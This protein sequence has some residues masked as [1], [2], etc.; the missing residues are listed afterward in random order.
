MLSIIAIA[1]WL[2]LVLI[3]NAIHPSPSQPIEAYIQQLKTQRDMLTALMV[4]LPIP[5]L[6]L[7]V[8]FIPYVN[9]LDVVLSW[10]YILT[11]VFTI[12]FMYRLE[13]RHHYAVIYTTDEN[14]NTQAFQFFKAAVNKIAEEE[15]LPIPECVLLRDGRPGDRL[16]AGIALTGHER[17]VIFINNRK[18]V[19][20]D[21]ALIAAIVAHEMGH[22]KYDDL[23]RSMSF[24]SPL[25]STIG[26]SLPLFLSISY[27]L[28]TISIEGSILIPLLTFFPIYLFA[29][30]AAN[31]VYLAIL[32]KSEYMAD[33]YGVQFAGNESMK[34]LI[35]HAQKLEEEEFP[36]LPAEYS[37]K[38]KPTN[39]DIGSSHPSFKKRIA[40]FDKMPKTKPKI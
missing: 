6:S 24:F 25:M 40:A 33:A 9:I 7:F 36:L 19:A 3:V 10:P 17:Y 20:L 16:E 11:V 12:L 18:I 28:L 39:T 34:Q 23:P 30:Q 29:T 38:K 15:G 37:P 1:T 8:W 27:L 32:R 35:I 4:L 2:G 13:N 22:L 31:F 26:V 14:Q 21:N 5:V